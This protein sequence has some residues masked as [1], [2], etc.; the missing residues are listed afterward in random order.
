MNNSTEHNSS[1]KHNTF[2]RIL[3]NPRNLWN[4]TEYYH[5]HK[6]PNTISW[7]IQIMNILIMRNPPFACRLITFTLFSPTLYSEVPQLFLSFL[8]QLKFHTFTNQQAKIFFFLFQTINFLNNKF[9]KMNL[10]ED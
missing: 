1:S 8:K 10:K 6:R 7:S 9:K 3:N 5:L 4:A 2:T